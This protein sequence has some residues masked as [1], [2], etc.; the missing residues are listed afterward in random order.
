MDEPAVAAELAKCPIFEDLDA[1]EL[2]EFARV[3][4]MRTCAKGEYLFHEDDPADGL[5]VLVS[6]HIKIHK[7]SPQGKE[8]ILRLVRP[9]EMFAEAA[10]LSGR[11]YPAAAVALDDSVALCVGRDDFMRLVSANPA[12]SLKMLGHLSQLL[13]D[14]SRLVEELSLADVPSRLARYLIDLADRAGADEFELGLAK[15]ELA[16]RLGMAPETLSR[17]IRRF[18][19][20]GALVMHGN[21]V[22]L[23]DRALM[24]RVSDGRVT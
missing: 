17:T 16:T 7:T 19:E 2:A 18:V 11:R 20:Q 6:G 10:V 13:R 5:Y 14:V 15:G 22:R 21:R 12:V 23:A 8:Q 3:A 1:D 9:V 4:L 24:E